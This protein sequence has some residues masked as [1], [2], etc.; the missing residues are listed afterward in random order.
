MVTVMVTG[1]RDW[2]DEEK[3]HAELDRISSEAGFGKVRVLQG[4]CPTGADLHARNWCELEA[5]EN[6]PYPPDPGRGR[7]GFLDRNLA[8]VAAGPDVVL[9]FLDPSSRGTW[10]AVTAAISAGIEVRCFGSEVVSDYLETR[11]RQ[12]ASKLISGQ[13]WRS[14]RRKALAVQLAAVRAGDV[15][16]PGLAEAI[17][18]TLEVRS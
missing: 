13:G 17:D 5:R 12:A 3:V 10:H 2:G 9:A 8:M 7:Q 16:A 1:S 14:G 18:E 4:E 6:V 11:A 15:L